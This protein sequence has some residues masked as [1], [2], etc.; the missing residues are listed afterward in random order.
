[1]RGFRPLCVLALCVLSA[2]AQQA[3]SGACSTGVVVISVASAAEAQSL[4]DALTCTGGGLFEVTWS[5]SVAVTEPFQVSGGSTLN[6]TGE[7][8]FAPGFVLDD[9]GMSST[10]EIAA[11][12]GQGTDGIFIVSGSSTLTLDN[13][14]LQGG[15]SSA[16]GGAIH[17]AGAAIGVRDC[18]FLNNGAVGYGG[19]QQGWEVSPIHSL[20]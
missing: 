4:A 15:N 12:I 17:A 13:L 19:K 7:V 16:G 8:G 10:G 2:A 1:M 14:V 11:A 18:G 9:D 5:G 20:R 6:I 3:V